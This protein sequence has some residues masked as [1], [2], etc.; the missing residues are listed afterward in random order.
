[1]T[2]QSP[3]TLGIN[4]VQVFVQG[5]STV[6]RCDGVHP[7]EM[8]MLRS[9]Y[10][11]CQSEAHALTRFDDLVKTDLSLE[12]ARQVLDSTELRIEFLRSCVF[13][14]YADGS[15]SNAERA[16]V[17]EFAAALRIEAETVSEIEAE[18]ADVLMQ[19]MAPLQNIDA[20]REVARKTLKGD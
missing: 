2:N 4:H 13:L 12:H 19:Q 7:A 9:F 1:M 18:V 11:S 17:H 3:I 20:V 15:Y 10:D 8:T 6:S 5:M 14:G 16:K